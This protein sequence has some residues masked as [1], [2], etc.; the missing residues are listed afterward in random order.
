[1][2]TT[3]LMILACI[4][5]VACQREW[6]LEKD[7]RT[8]YD[9]S[10]ANRTELSINGTDFKMEFAGKAS[11]G[12]Y[13][14]LRMTGSNEQFAGPNQPLYTNMLVT[15]LD[16]QTKVKSSMVCTFQFGRVTSIIY[17]EEGRLDCRLL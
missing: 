9:S 7:V 14:R 2:R 16:L 12:F 11:E 17:T 4:S 3:I 1:M 15:V 13:A 5:L 8:V 10:S 6:I